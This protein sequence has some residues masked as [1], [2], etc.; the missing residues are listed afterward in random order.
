[1]P[2][3]HVLGQ[4]PAIRTLTGALRAGRVHHAYRFEG[5]EGVGK[6]LVAFAVAQALVCER[7]D[8]LG[9]GACDACRRAVTLS[10]EEPHTPLHPDVSLVERGLYPPE[11]L[12]RSRPELNEISV[13]QVRRVV[14]SHM[15]F[16]PHG[17][18]ARVYIVRRA[19]ELSISA[20]NALLK[21]LEEPRPSTHFILLTSRPDRLLDTIRSRTMPVRFAPLSEE[22]VRGVLRARGIAAERH[23]LALELAAGSASA[24]I[25]HADP[26]LT[27]E[28]EELVRRVLTA[29]SA[30]D[31]GPGVAFAESSESNRLALRRDLAAVAAALARTARKEVAADP[32]A[33]GIAAQRYEAV[34]QAII[35]LEKNASTSLALIQLVAEMRAAR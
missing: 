29:V 17:G 14:L 31:L 5:P 23:D 9:C 1:V 32:R 34:A 24:A 6:E 10:K 7:Q 4:E 16:A 12:G 20:A 33:A 27:A 26:E 18:R 8:P 30:R 15:S 25:E 3:A 19:E 22:I 2:F 28:R 35:R 21:T 11:T 13:D